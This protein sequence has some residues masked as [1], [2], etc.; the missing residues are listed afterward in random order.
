MMHTYTYVRV[1]IYIHHYKWLYILLPYKLD[2]FDPVYLY[3]Q[4]L[5]QNKN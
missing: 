4:S 5:S 3:R 1:Y 2:F